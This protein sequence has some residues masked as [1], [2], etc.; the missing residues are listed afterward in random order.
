MNIKYKV[1]LS[2][3]EC[4][5]LEELTSKGKS[6]ARQIKRAQILL[7]SNQR[8]N[9]DHEIVELLSTCTSTIYR[10]K[11]DFVEYGLDAA[12]KEGKRPGQPRKLDANQRGVI[13]VYCM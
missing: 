7:M 13:S 10:T 8:T 2:T 1:V 6:S 4:Q 11:R 5:A 9:E 12:L 3:A